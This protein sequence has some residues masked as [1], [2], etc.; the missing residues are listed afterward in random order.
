MAHSSFSIAY[1]LVKKVVI[2]SSSWLLF[3]RELP[4]LDWR[5][6]IILVK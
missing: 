4:L 3:W 2:A 5:I 6:L 1:K